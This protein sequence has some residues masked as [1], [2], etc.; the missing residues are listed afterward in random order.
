MNRNAMTYRLFP[1]VFLLASTVATAAGTATVT[2]PEKLREQPG[3]SSWSIMEL[4]RRTTVRVLETRRDWV[5]VEADGNRRGWVREQSLSMDAPTHDSFASPTR[6]PVGT[7][8]PPVPRTAPRASN[9]ALILSLGS[10]FP[11]SRQDATHA[12]AIARLMGVPDANIRQPAQAELTLD[13]LR[14]ALVD[15][16]AR[17]GDRD[18]AFIHVSGNSTRLREAGRCSTGFTLPTSK[19]V[20]TA[21]EL[22]AHV[23]S[24]AHRADKLVLLIDTRAGAGAC[25]ASEDTVTHNLNEGKSRNILYLG[26]TQEASATPVDSQGG[27]FTQALLAC[28]DGRATLS[29]AAGMPTGR[30]LIDCTR[31]TL[32]SRPG[33]RPLVTLAGN[34]NL[35][36]A[37]VMPRGDAI[38]PHALLTALHAQR[39]ERRQI[40]VNGLRT[41]Y[42]A[43]GEPMRFTLT[44][45]QPGYLHVVAASNDGFTLLYPNQIDPL[46]RIEHTL[47]VSLP[48]QD[49]QTRPAPRASKSKATLLFLVTDGPRNFFRAG[50]SRAGAFAAAPADARTLRDLPLEILGGDNSPTCTRSET[51]NLGP[52]Q[53]LLCS[54]SFGSALQEIIETP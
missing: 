8:L 54:T 2:Q 15:L 19:D 18:R 3:S 41:N 37:P 51:R 6:Q 35:I 46:G 21:T 22:A 47:T 13:G 1:A 44:S 7:D 38:S 14:K 53:L 52:S 20:L 50:L 26:A 10:A 4:H 12:A 49:N 36:P 32:A 33:A 29:A 23:R 40:S 39:D 11:A 28:L 45:S 34:G 30:E 27:L 17:M 9:H 43:G 42:R 48:A 16:D 24:L 5:Q 25:Q 31:T